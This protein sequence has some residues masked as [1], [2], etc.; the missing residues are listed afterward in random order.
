MWILS[1][2]KYA[3]CGFATFLSIIGALTRYGGALCLF[4]GLI[5]GGIICLAI[6]VGFHYL[7]EAVAKKK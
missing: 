2:K 5:P 4:S 3:G 1:Y 7:A 6:G